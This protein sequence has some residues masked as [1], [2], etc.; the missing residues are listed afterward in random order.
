[1]RQVW[2]TTIQREVPRWLA[3]L[4]I[5]DTAVYEGLPSSDFT[6]RSRKGTGRFGEDAAWGTRPTTAGTAQVPRQARDDGMGE[7]P[8]TAWPRRSVA[9]RGEKPE[10]DPTRGDPPPPRLR[11]TGAARR[12]YRGRHGMDS[13]AR[14]R[15]KYSDKQSVEMSYLI[16][17]KCLYIGLR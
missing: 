4:G 5:F 2:R 1:M 10:N 17:L 12:G 7:W 15:R 9:L 13:P 6:K 16:D 11:R 8:A 14:Q 3:H